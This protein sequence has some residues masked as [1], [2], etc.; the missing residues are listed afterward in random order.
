MNDAS[1]NGYSIF[2]NDSDKM[3]QL[4]EAM[5]K[6]VDAA[7]AEDFM[8]APEVKMDFAYQ[9]PGKQDVNNMIPGNTK[10]CTLYD[11]KKQKTMTK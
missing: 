2:Q 10:Q 1:G 3:K 9:F 4:L 6:D 8:Q 7:T 11:R 5:K